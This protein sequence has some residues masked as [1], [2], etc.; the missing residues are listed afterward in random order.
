MKSERSLSQPCF[1]NII[2]LGLLESSWYGDVRAE[3]FP[4][5]TFIQKSIAIGLP[6]YPNVISY[7][8]FILGGV[9]L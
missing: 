1:D 2:S 4:H 7:V 8:L 3:Y 9:E 6:G 5:V